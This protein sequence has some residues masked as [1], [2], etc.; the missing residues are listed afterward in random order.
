MPLGDIRLGE[1]STRLTLKFGRNENGLDN[2]ERNKLNAKVKSQTQ[3]TKDPLSMYLTQEDLGKNLFKWDY[4]TYKR[5]FRQ[6]N[7]NVAPFQPRP[8]SFDMFGKQA[9]RYGDEVLITD[10]VQEKSVININ[11]AVMAE[12][13]KGKERLMTRNAFAAML[14]PV[15][16]KKTNAA[17]SSSDTSTI[18]LNNGRIGAFVTRDAS[19]TNGVGAANGTDGIKLAIPDTDAFFYLFRKFTDYN[20]DPGE[21]P[22]IAVTPNF[23]HILTRM[24]AYRNKEDIYQAMAQFEKTGIF[25]WKGFKF[26]QVTPEVSP[27]AFYAGKHLTKDILDET[28]KDTNKDIP[29]TGIH[30]ANIGAGTSTAG[31]DLTTTNHE[32]VSCWFK[33]NV[34]KITNKQF[35]VNDMIRLDYLRKVPIYYMEAW[36]GGS[37]MEDVLQFNLIIPKI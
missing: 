17:V 3:T 22:C 15:R 29:M 10:F 27:G 6:I 36:C 5:D 37:R 21:V 20:V 24:T 2:I 23:M 7:Q 30:V 1:D 13:Q 8:Q 12:M 25:G 35:D 32:V 19:N 33:K 31:F 16:W 9:S 11:T 28:G 34:F 18:E 4:F 14:N 26:I